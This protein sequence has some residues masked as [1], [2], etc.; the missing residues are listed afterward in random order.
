MYD[1]PYEGF[2][3]ISPAP[4]VQRNL[5]N[6]VSYSSFTQGANPAQYNQAAFYSY[7]IHGNVDMLLQD[8]GRSE[9]TATQNIMN[10]NNNRFKK[11]VYTYDL[12]SGKVNTVA[13]QPGQPDQFYHRYRYDAENRLTEAG[14]SSDSVHWQQDARYEYYQH[15]PLARLVLGEEQVQG[16][17]YAYTL[18]GWLKGGNSTQL[19]PEQDMASDGLSSSQYQYIA[20]DA[21]V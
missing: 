7:D 9:E 14:T 5:R 12:I 16:V 1:W 10:T 17:D 20:R 19:H 6:R 13:Y 18:Q 4:V 11:L 15:G 2:T 8:Y 3:G 21:V